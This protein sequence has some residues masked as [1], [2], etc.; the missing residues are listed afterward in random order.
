MAHIVKTK[1][2]GISMK[3]IRRIMSL[4]LVLTMML[5]GINV[6]AAEDEGNHVGS[7]DELK[8]VS[9]NMETGEI[10]YEVH[11]VEEL[12]DVSALEIQNDKYEITPLYDG[13]IG[14]D[15]RVRITNTTDSPY[16][17]VCYVE[18][19]FSDGF[20]CRASGVLVYFDVVL[21]CGHCVYSSEHGGFAKSVKVIPAMNGENSAPL[22]TAYALGA[23]IGQSWIDNKELN[24]DWAIVDL[25]KSFST[26]QLFGYYNDIYSQ[27]GTSVTSIGYPKQEGF[28][29]YMYSDTNSITYATEYQYSTLCDMS[30]GQSGGVLIDDRSG[31]LI[32]I[33]ANINEIKP[34][35]EYANRCIRLAPELCSLIQEHYD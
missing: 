13:I 16:R 14:I 30:E 22:G 27:L 33:N 12:P 32:G 9:Y 21:T 10:T 26:W 23:S 20:F 24:G 35:E 1:N 18:S 11:Q 8:T 34:N 7:V 19:T 25:D 6:Y 5:T 31:Y 15:N 2:G 17:N 4:G 28:R 3:T 29:F